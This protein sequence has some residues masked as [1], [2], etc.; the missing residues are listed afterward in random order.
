MVD[1]EK[2]SSSSFSDHAQIAEN[3]TLAPS[4][5][6]ARIAYKLKAYG[7]EAHGVSPVKVEQQTYTNFINLFFLWLSANTCLISVSTGTLGP[8]FF[9]LGLR[10]SALVILFMNAACCV[11]P[12]YFSTF[13]PI[14]G[15]R[16]MIFARYSLGYIGAVIISCVNIVVFM[17]FLILNCIL[18]GQSLASASNGNLSWNVG[19]VIIALISLLLTFSGYKVLNIYERYA[20]IPVTIVF[21]ITV[22]IGGKH[23]KNVPPPAPATASQV[24]TFA[25]A[26]A[27]F[28]LSWGTLAADYTI[29][30][31]PTVPK[32]KIFTYAYLGFFLPLVLLEILG[33]SLAVASNA[34][35]EWALGYQRNNLGGLFAAVLKPAGRFGKFCMVVL[36]MSVP[37]AC[38]PTMYSFGISFQ[39]VAPWFAKLP[40]YV[41]S[42]ISTAILIP[43]AIVGAKHFDSALLHFLE[44]IAYYCSPFSAVLLVEHIAFRS[45][46]GERYDRTLW[47]DFHALPLGLAGLG[48]IILSFGLIIPSMDQIWYVGPIAKTGAGDI[49]FELGFFGAALFYSI[50][51]PIERLLT[52][53]KGD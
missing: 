13:G 4:T 28:I 47:N 27:G 16:Q 40:R 53:R 46:S 41:F 32:A 11:I 8:I 51:R 15:L 1:I 21:I 9:G 3:N 48:S 10:D 45:S 6:R 38:A 33:A 30:M 25:S 18:G 29:Y 23:I 19:I 42:V 20:W 12:A 26:I 22:G 52:P 34:N 36:A 37:A 44:I 50:L 49:G 2:K 17:G 43:L 31:P 39:C 5:L 7:V 14:T 24:L 35:Q